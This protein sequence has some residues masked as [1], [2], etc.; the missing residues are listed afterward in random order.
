MDRN[1]LINGE[2]R[3]IN[4]EAFDEMLEDYV[5]RNTKLPLEPSLGQILNFYM[6][7]IIAGF[8]AGVSVTTA[9]FVLYNQILSSH[10]NYVTYDYLNTNGGGYITTNQFLTDLN[11]KGFIS[12][13]GLPGIMFDIL[14]TTPY[15]FVTMTFLADYLLS[16]SYVQANTKSLIYYTVSS[17]LNVV[18]I[19]LQI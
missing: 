9:L 10:S 14:Q 1:Q 19:S 17:D 18:V 3:G 8:T 2:E 6:W 7:A 12:E 13:T 5:R 4:Q 11:S 16:N 15:G